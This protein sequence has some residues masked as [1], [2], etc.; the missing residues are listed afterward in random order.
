[1]SQSDARKPRSDVVRRRR[2][3]V[4]G[5]AQAFKVAGYN[6]PVEV[7]LEYTGVGRGTL[8]RHFPTRND[9][10][11]AVLDDQLQSFS[12]QTHAIE[13]PEAFLDFI[14]GM[15]T[16]SVISPS[17]FEAQ[18]EVREKLDIRYVEAIGPIIEKACRR[19]WIPS[20][21]TIDDFA[22]VLVM[23][24]AA[25]RPLDLAARISGADRVVRVLSQGVLPREPI[26]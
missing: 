22:L 14:T 9:L 23:A 10:I 3:I 13:T 12:A 20:D 4:D 21:F 17:F 26:A 8:Y 1:M 16:E 2:E 18:A 19:N 5:S 7:V 25:L 15:I 11:F 24:G 6:A